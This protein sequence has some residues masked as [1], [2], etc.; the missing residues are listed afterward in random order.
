MPTDSSTDRFGF[1]VRFVCG[2]LFGA[3]LS[4]RGAFLYN[5]SS[6][7]LMV[8]AGALICGFGAAKC[9]DSFWERTLGSWP[10]WN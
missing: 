8:I 5:G 6:A 1:W 3:F 2:A 7:I 10:W 4:L 9:G